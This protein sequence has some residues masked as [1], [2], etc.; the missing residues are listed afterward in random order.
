MKEAI[1]HLNIKA[2]AYFK[3]A[4]EESNQ[5]IKDKLN[6]KGLFVYEIIKELETINKL[7][8]V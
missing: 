6:D 2:L 8:T 3:V 7:E 1:N 5:E 4:A